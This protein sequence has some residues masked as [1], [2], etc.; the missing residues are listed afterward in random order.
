M[1][2][3]ST[4]SSGDGSRPTTSGGVDNIG[5]GQKFTP[6]R[7]GSSAPADEKSPAHKADK[8]QTRGDDSAP[9]GLRDATRTTPNTEPPATATDNHRD[10]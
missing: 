8:A 1:S 3:P 4:S 10:R 2:N 6:G 7:P 9:L 5:A